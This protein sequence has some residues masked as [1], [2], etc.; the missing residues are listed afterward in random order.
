MRVLYL[1]LDT[2]RPDRLGCYGYSRNTS[3]NIDRIAN[4]GMKFTNY[5]CADAPCLP[6]RSGFMSGQFGIHSGVV[7]HGG[8]AADRRLEGQGRGFS[9]DYHRMNLAGM[10]RLND[11]HTV[12]ISPFAERHSAWWFN[13]GF[14]ETHNTGWGGMESA[15]HITPTVLDWLNRNAESDNWFLHINYW[16]SHGPYRAPE[17]FGNPFEGQPGGS[18][19]V[20]DEIFNRH[21]KTGGPHTC[22]DIGMYSGEVPNWN[23]NRY[24]L[25]LH[26]TDDVK[27]F[28][29]GYDCGTAY[30]DSHIGQ[31]FSLLENKGVMEDLVII[32]T[33]DHAE[34]MGELGI[35][36]EHGTADYS[37]CRIPMIIRFPGKI[38]EGTVAEGKHYNVDLAPTLADLF[39]FDKHDKWDGN[40]FAK[41]LTHG[42]DCG[43]EYV[44]VSQCAHVCQRGVR[45]GPWMYIRTYH[46]GFHPNIEDE[47]LFNIEDDPHEIINLAPDKRD[48]CHQGAYYLTEWH[49]QMMAT[50]PNGYTTDP[51]RTVIAEGGPFHANPRFIGDLSEYLKRLEK[52][53]RT[54][55]ADIIR[56]RH[57]NIT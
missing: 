10:F 9:E 53:G 3:P 35:Y 48:I 37:T 25:E 56:Q 13:A 38:A 46:D 51:M 47:M 42:E 49:D 12:T 28:S 54:E 4:E 8:T 24:P 41:T 44:V 2:L 22:Q 20:T 27:R 33:S 29:D 14:R 19:W 16:D 34:N 43:R 31:I 45:F 7:G 39:V 11:Y 17:E 1:D 5:Y 6:S 55:S 15:E 30:M 52:T 40:S 26:N 21:H 36:A 18:D 50:M 32:I 57:P 23:Y